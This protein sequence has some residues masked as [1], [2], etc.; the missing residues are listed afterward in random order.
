MSRAFLHSLAKFITKFKK[1][2]TIKLTYDPVKLNLGSGLSVCRGWIHIDATLTALYTKWPRWILK[3]LYKHSYAKGMMPEEEFIKILKDH[4]FVHHN[5]AYGIPLPDNTV[6]YIYSSHFLEHLFKADAVK[7]LKEAYRCL[8][9]S[10][11]I[12][13]CVPDLD[14]AFSLYQEKKKEEALTYFFTDTEAGYLERHRYMYDFALLKS[15][16]ESIGFV[17][18]IRCSY[19]QGNTPDIDKLDNRSEETL[20]VEAR[21][22]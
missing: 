10:G 19:Q 4:A 5:L 9:K 3:K 20:Y 14:Y 22:K 6:D 7:L 18:V 2:Q 13:I 16:L 11:M 17:D 15:I 21:K 8:K 1:K 12:R